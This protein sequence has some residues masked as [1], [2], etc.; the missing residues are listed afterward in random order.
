MKLLKSLIFA[1]ALGSALSATAALANHRDWPNPRLESTRGYVVVPRT[2]GNVVG[3]VTAPPAY[4][5]E[6]G[7]SYYYSEPAPR[8]YYYEPAP[9]VTYFYDDPSAFPRSNSRD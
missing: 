3:Y 2:Q 4:Y 1:G 9:T 7:P 8:Y 5:Y 6:P